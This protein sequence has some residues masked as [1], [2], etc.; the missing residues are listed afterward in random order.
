MPP[1]LSHILQPLDVSCFSPLKYLYSQRTQEKIQDEVHSIGKE[2]FLHIY[3]AV[4]Q[5]AL[6]SSNIRS[7]FAATGLIPFSPE[8]VLSKLNI[9]HKTPTPPSSSHSNQSFG[10]G[11]TPANIYK[12]EKQKQRIE[13]LRGVVS[14][15]TVD[16]AMK[17]VIKGAEMTMQN[18]ILLQQRVD[19]L[20]SE[21]QYRKT[22]RERTRQ[23]IK[24]GGSLMVA[25]ARKKA[26]EQ[27]E[28]EEQTE[29]QVQQSRPR[30]PTKCS[31]CGA[32]GHNRLRCPSK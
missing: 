23:F 11:K 9:Q 1:H 21:N 16:E 30:R 14:P 20:Q 32:F 10:A 2:D 26:Q 5:K 28:E 13:S 24:N 15:S 29:N 19:K 3:P 8:R 31:N 22:R 4:H 25:E 18:A 17:K 27:R 6:S 7:G 12:L